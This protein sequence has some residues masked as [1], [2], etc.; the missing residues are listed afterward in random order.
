MLRKPRFRSVSNQEKYIC[1]EI[2]QVILNMVTRLRNN[3]KARF[4]PGRL[5]QNGNHLYK[6]LCISSSGHFSNVPSA[7]CCSLDPEGLTGNNLFQCH[8]VR[9]S[10]WK[11][12][13]WYS[14][15]VATFS[16]FFFFFFQESNIYLFFFPP[17]CC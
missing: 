14:V 9:I 2:L 10:T 15:G 1:S 13:S 8:V 17:P 11:C 7:T 6:Q 4:H 3:E 12:I 16:G 5:V